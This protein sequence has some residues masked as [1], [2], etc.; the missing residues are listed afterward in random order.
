MDEV[1]K[2]RARFEQ[3][4][5]A[6]NRQ[7]AVVDGLSAQTV[8]V[9]NNIKA[10]PKLG[11]LHERGL[12]VTYDFI[13]TKKIFTIDPKRPAAGTAKWTLNLKNQYPENVDNA[14][15]DL[16][17]QQVGAAI[18]R[19]AS[20]GGLGK[21]FSASKPATATAASE[22]GNPNDS[23]EAAKYYR[24]ESVVATQVFEVEDPQ[25]EDRVAAFL[26]THVNHHREPLA[27]PPSPVGYRNSP[28]MLP[29]PPPSAIEDDQSP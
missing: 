6:V 5:S 27:P 7:S 8:A 1:Q 4:Q 21:F 17:I 3:S 18:E 20:S 25:V 26:E 11:E 19:I 29:A 24:L 22:G 13:K 15:S 28:P 9:A 23:D 2:I 16:T 12:H 10:N 14:I